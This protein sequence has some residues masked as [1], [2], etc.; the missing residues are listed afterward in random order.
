MA[1]EMFNY[2]K[3][4]LR[5]V[6]FDVN[7]F[8]KEVVKAVSRLLPHEIEELKIWIQSLL[9]HQPELRSSLI[10]LKKQ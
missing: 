10:Y 5:K 8:T 2:T 9:V 1:R 7:L 4:I 3:T 6:S